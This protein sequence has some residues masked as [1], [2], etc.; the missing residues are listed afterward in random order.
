MKA[1]T[2]A[3]VSV[4][5]ILTIAK[6]GAWLVSDSVS[7]LSSLVDSLL[8]A[9]ASMVSLLAVRHAL[10]PADHEHR[11]GHGK[12][13]SLA[14]LGQA[15]FIAGSGVFLILQAVERLLYEKP[16]FQGELGIA[17]MGI[18]TVLTI[19][20]VAFQAYVVRRTGS[21]AIKADSVHY[22]VDILVNV[23]VIVSLILST[24][25]GWGRAD[26]IFAIL[27]VG[28]MGWGAVAIGRE[29]YDQLMDRELP[30][31]ERA[32]IKEIV[33][34]HPKVHSVH[35]MR[36]RSSG[37]NQF[38]Q[39]HVEMDKDISL[40]EAHEI[41]DAVMYDVEEAFPNAEVLIHQ[42]PEGVD[43]RRDEIQT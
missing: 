4:A 17:I 28:Y 33:L 15:M 23:A 6:L 20:L 10:Q 13:E 29:A 21:L 42:D 16:V 38:I 31:E 12:A 32:K 18:A 5:V 40:M 2:Y 8:D 3:S 27:I 11:Y 1:A 41:G 36:T 43:E 26:P 37:P 30:D 22:R 9:G 34:R 19:G 35:D 39:L 25:I 24:Q 14:G 7:L